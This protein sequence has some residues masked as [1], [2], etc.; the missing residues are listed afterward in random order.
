MLYLLFQQQGIYSDISL[1]AFLHC[2]KACLLQTGGFG[3]YL[4]M[5]EYRS[6]SNMRIVHLTSSH[7]VSSHQ[8]NRNLNQNISTSRIRNQQA[9]DTPKS[10]D[11]SYITHQRRPALIPAGIELS[12]EDEQAVRLRTGYVDPLAKRDAVFFNPVFL[13]DESCVSSAGAGQAPASSKRK[14]SALEG[15]EEG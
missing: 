13:R 12:P 14:A 1:A 5:N 10:M 7:H 9:S 6:L 2:S 8:A 4:T 3:F 15:D 11:Q